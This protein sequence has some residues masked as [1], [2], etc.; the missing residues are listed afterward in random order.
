MTEVQYQLL[1]IAVELAVSSQLRS[2]TIDRLAAVQKALENMTNAENKLS[3]KM[4]N[5][6]SLVI[7]CNGEA[8]FNINI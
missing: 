4:Q 8:Q 5:S 1:K 2:D 3:C 7:Y 6:C